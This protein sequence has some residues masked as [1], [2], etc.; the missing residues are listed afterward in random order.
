MTVR[1]AE[2]FAGIGGFRIGFDGANK[3]LKQPGLFKVVWSN[4]WEPGEK[5]QHA[6]RVY[7]DQMV[8]QMKTS[9]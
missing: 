7:E 9:Q 3:K 5:A 6:S 8:T 1:I 2:L 4:Q